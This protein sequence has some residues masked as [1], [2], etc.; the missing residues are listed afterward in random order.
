MLQSPQC[1]L[2]PGDGALQSCREGR[3][4]RAGRASAD[5]LLLDKGLAA[6]DHH[7]A[8]LEDTHSPV[9]VAGAKVGVGASLYL[10]LSL[11]SPPYGCLG[12]VAAALDPAAAPCYVYAC[13]GL[14][15][16]IAAKHRVS[17]SAPSII[18]LCCLNSTKLDFAV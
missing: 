16:L 10:S 3:H 15:L 7:A 5:L 9:Q 1:V 6:G 8:D 17:L 4:E 12:S 11:P 14:P 2:W 13:T 18:W